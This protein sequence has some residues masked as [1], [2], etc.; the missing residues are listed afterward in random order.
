LFC[1]IFAFLSAIGYRT[2]GRSAIGAG[3]VRLMLWPFY[4]LPTHQNVS[5]ATNGYAVQEL[6]Y[7]IFCLPV[8]DR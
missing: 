2:E 5:A 1:I 6:F 8:R 3:V 4:W 7:L